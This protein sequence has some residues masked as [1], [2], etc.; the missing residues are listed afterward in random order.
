MRKV[1]PA[2]A[3]SGKRTL[4]IDRYSGA[5]LEDAPFERYGAVARAIEWGVAIHTGVAFGRANQ[6]AMLAAVLAILGLIGT[7][8][9]MWL[10]RRPSGELG[11]P[12]SEAA[13]P[14]WLVG[15]VG[16]MG[17]LFPLVGLSL[18]PLL[19]TELVRKLRTAG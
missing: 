17:L 14:L 7:G 5:V 16:G 13:P 15:M 4:Q 3:P 18:V 11:A 2:L 9:W 12:Q 6:I 8:V 10:K 1:W 19:G